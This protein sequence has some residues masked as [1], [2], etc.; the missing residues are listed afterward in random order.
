MSP[1]SNKQRYAGKT[2]LVSAG[3]SGIGRAIVEGLATE[4]C[5]LVFSDINDSAGK[6]VQS[7]L[8]RRGLDALFVQSDGT[9]ATA[10][11]DLV[12][13]AV[14]RLGGLDVAINNVGA[15][16][17][18]ELPQMTMDDLSPEIW[19]ASIQ[20]SLTSCFLA[21]K[22]ELACMKKHGH[23]VIANTASLAGLRI[24]NSTP[25]YSSAKA[26]VIHLTKFVAVHYAKNNIRCNCVAPGMTTTS[27][28]IDAF[29]S[30]AERDQLAASKH[31]IGR[32]IEPREIADAFLWLCSDEA[33][34]VTGQC[35][36][37]DGGWAA[38]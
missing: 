35:I 1:L 25:A 34:M 26:G 21:M 15:H 2:A 16:P 9:S 7:A 4:G 37:V 20:Q 12:E 32:M 13:F 36:A 22:Y 28:F 5:Q 38:A 8:H 3:A 29:P 30:A 11:C 24:I 33:S 23:G 10:V 19:A 17:K 31:P 27:A 6:A 14:G 18:G